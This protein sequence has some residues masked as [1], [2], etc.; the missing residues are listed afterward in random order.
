MPRKH[1]KPEGIVAKLRQVDVLVSQG[2]NITDA[3]RQIGVSEV[4]YYLSLLKN[5]FGLE[6]GLPM[7]AKVDD[8]LR[9]NRAP[10]SELSPKSGDG[11]ICQAALD[12]A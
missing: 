5:P 11:L 3:I 2:Q 8:V 9:S 6:I 4:T 12:A 10:L 1:H 7:K